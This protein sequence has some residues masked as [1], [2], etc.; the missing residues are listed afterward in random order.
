MPTKFSINRNVFK[1]LALLRL[2]TERQLISKD[3]PD[4]MY[5]KLH[6]RKNLVLEIE[7]FM[8]Q[9]GWLSKKRIINRIQTYQNCRY[10][11]SLAIL[12]L[13]ETSPNAFNTALWNAS[14]KFKSLIGEN[15]IELIHRG[16]DAI[17]RRQFLIKVG[18]LNSTKLLSD[19][20]VDLLPKPSLS[21]SVFY[22][23]EC[24]NELK[25]LKSL[26]LRNIDSVVG[27]LDQNKLAF[28]R[29]LLDTTDS[30]YATERELVYKFLE[31]E[32]NSLDNLIIL[33]EAEAVS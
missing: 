13:G 8:N 29:Y 28:L 32:I 30:T 12:E 20:V 1:E 21:D 33:L 27:R 17:A 19:K 11:A 26:T 22:A 16:E 15:T 5:Y 6:F 3:L 18:S 23:S 7:D 4:D 14:K 31:D 9:F 2:E 10:D 25:F 24:K